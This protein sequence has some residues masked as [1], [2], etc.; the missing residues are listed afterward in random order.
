[1]VLIFIRGPSDKYQF[2]KQFAHS[3]RRID[4][5]DA[6]NV[7]AKRQMVGQVARHR[8]AVIRHQDEMVFLAPDQDF[9]VECAAWWCTRIA[10]N[11]DLQLRCGAEK[12][13]AIGG[14]NVLI[15]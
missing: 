10:D 6:G 8:F 4:D 15:K 11:P 12:L 13:R 5:E 9:R 1:M 14:S 2:V 3:Q 7:P